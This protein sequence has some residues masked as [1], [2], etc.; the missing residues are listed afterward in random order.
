LNIDIPS[1]YEL[2][3]LTIGI[4]LNITVNI[5][6]NPAP[7]I[8]WVFRRNYSTESVIMSHSSSNG[9]EFTTHIFIHAINKTQFGSYIVIATNTIGSYNKT[10]SV[11]EQGNLYLSSYCKIFCVLLMY[12]L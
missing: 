9:F 6:A 10:F 1:S 5:L 2:I 12:F 3:A 7:T 4:S 8:Q 11:I